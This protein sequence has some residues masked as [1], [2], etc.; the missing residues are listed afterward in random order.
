M[1][2]TKRDPYFE[3]PPDEATPPVHDV[4]V[5]RARADDSA[6]SEEVLHP[7]D[8]DTDPNPEPPD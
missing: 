3:E 1:D 5:D 2:D 7:G 8:P 6:E 4:G